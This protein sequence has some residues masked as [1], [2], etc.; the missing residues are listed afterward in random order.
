MANWFYF[1][2]LG[3][4]RSVAKNEAELAAANEK[5]KSL[6]KKLQQNQQVL[7]TANIR[8][9]H[10]VRMY[11]DFYWFSQQLGECQHK[12][13]KLED[14]IKLKENEIE[15]LNVTLAKR[16]K[17]I[18]AIHTILGPQFASQFD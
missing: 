15:Q 9:A 11:L 17:V 6:E 8:D 1:P 18:D 2:L 14:D 13:T 5:I 16:Q 3:L 7:L 4:K 10:L 12:N